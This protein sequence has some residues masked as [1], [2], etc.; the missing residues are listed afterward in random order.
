MIL[1]DE[2]WNYE[3][4]KFILI[5]EWIVEFSDVPL[6]S[7]CPC[8][9]RLCASGRRSRSRQWFRRK[10]FR[11]TVRV[12]S[13]WLPLQIPPDWRTLPAPCACK[14]A[15]WLLRTAAVYP[16]CPFPGFNFKKKLRNY[17]QNG[18]GKWR[19]ADAENAAG[20][21]LRFVVEAEFAQVFAACVLASV[22]EHAP[23]AAERVRHSARFRIQSLRSKFIRKSNCNPNFSDPIYGLKR[24]TEP[25]K[26][27]DFVFNFLK[28]IFIIIKIA[29]KFLEVNHFSMSS[30][31]GVFVNTEQLW[32][33]RLD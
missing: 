2:I 26:T 24:M 33:I 32:M 7:R 25:P 27:S 9:A 21:Y 5:I 30:I 14:A 3:N 22:E 17:H 6:C 23:R 13:R 10:V 20:I 4:K 11:P 8:R 15:L 19:I 28:T 12:G 29:V 1:N 18:Q 16:Q 31:F